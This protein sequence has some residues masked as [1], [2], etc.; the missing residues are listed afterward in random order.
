LSTLTLIESQPL[1][2]VEYS[3]L[4]CEQ[5]RARQIAAACRHDRYLGVIWD[6]TFPRD[7]PELYA[8]LV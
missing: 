1:S 8:R 6:L 4:T 7:A 3:S 2:L 5:Q